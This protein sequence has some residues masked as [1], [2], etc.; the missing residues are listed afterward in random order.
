MHI[1]I[2]SLCTDDYFRNIPIINTALDEFVSNNIYTHQNWNTIVH[3]RDSK[4]VK[5]WCTMVIVVQMM[6]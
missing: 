4:W 6:V 2:C 5:S 1:I 3:A